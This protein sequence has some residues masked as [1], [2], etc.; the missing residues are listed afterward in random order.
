MAQEIN[1]G[2]TTRKHKGPVQESRVSPAHSPLVALSIVD[3]HLKTFLSFWRFGFGEIF[4]PE[5]YFRNVMFVIYFL[6]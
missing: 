6:C 3:V 1:N 4:S 2:A 5:M